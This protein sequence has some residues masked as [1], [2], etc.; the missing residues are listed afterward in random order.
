VASFRWGIKRSH[1]TLRLGCLGCHRPK[2]PIFG[3][4]KANGG[5]G[6]GRATS[7]EIWIW[8]PDHGG[9]RPPATGPSPQILLPGVREWELGVSH[10]SC[11]LNAEIAKITRPA[12][13]R[14]RQCP[15]EHRDHR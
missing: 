5:P 7:G 1:V 6:T 15:R 10:R 11:C 12:H 3:A 8:D 4:R 9:G 13:H 2:R 14:D